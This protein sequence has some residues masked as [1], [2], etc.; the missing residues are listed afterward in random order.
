MC[1]IVG[2]IG[3]KEALPILISGLEALEYRGYDSAGVAIVSENGIHIKKRVGHVATLRASLE[4]N[5]SFR[6]HL[7]IAHTRWATHGAP[8]EENAHPHVDCHNRIFVVHNGIIENYAELKKF[9]IARG[10]TFVSETDTESIAHLIEELMKHG[11]SSSEAFVE[12][13]TMI[14][15]AY[16]LAMVDAKDPET[17]YATRLSSPLVIGIGEHEHF[18]ASDPSA[19]IGITKKIIYLRD[20]EIATIKRDAI[21]VHD[22][23]AMPISVSI[24]ELEWDI[25]QAQKGAFPHFML[26]EIFEGPDV[27]RAALRGRLNTAHY[28]IKLG[29]LDEVHARLQKAKKC[30]ILACGTSYYA[31]LLGEYLLEEIARIPTEV[32]FA[33]EFRYRDE[34]LDT[35]T[36]VIAISQSGETADTLAALRKAKE[37]GLLTLG[38]VNVVG[39]T[40][41]RETDAG[42]YNHAGPEMSVASTKAFL[43]QVT[44]LALIALSRSP[45][46]DAHYKAH[47]DAL[48]QIPSH[49][50]T[51]LQQSEKIKNLAHRYAHYKNFLYIGRRYNYPTALEGALKLKEI[52]YI[53]AE[54]CSAGEMKHGPIAMIHKDF[55][56][57]AIAPTNSVVEKMHSNLHEIK[58]RKGPILAI[59]SEGDEIIHTIA[60]DVIYIPKTLEPFEPL[61]ATVPLQLF[62]YYIGTTLGHNVDKPRNLAKSVTVE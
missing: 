24:T 28:T 54:G 11:K 17:L 8:T 6:G 32:Q 3:K 14:K 22:I 36:V 16:A 18:I 29:G 21:Q 5:A 13:L 48:A 56:T 46:Q 44:T 25:D 34:P 39:S 1:G 62:A 40:I 31:G 53:H 55:P 41:S 7:G 33:S 51:I 43:S 12:A 61:L 59:A 50:T 57:V 4:G 23:H 60:D 26:K 9:L 2:Y 58:A 38:V 45:T 52:S 10:H 15:G 27:I 35:N 49:I 42:I 37:H 20:G 19:L 47:I 30:I